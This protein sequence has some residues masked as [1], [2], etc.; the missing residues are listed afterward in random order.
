MGFS[1]RGYYRSE[2]SSFMAEWTAVLTIIVVNIAVWVANLLGA[3][4]FPVNSFLALEGDLP[5]HLLRAWELVTYGFVHDS[6]NPWHLVFNMLALWFFGREVEAVMGRGEFFRFYITAIVLAGIAWLVSVQIGAPLQAAR[7][8]LVGASGAVMAVFAVFIWYYPNQTVLLWGVLP[9]PAWALGILYFVSD[10]QGAAAGGGQVANVAHLAGAIFGLVYAW[11]G[12][13]LGGLA[14]LTARF[15]RQRMRVVRP[16]DDFGGR[17]SRPA[18]PGRP[19]SKLD[20][21]LQ[22]AVDKI[23]EKISRSGESSLTPEERDTLTR[24]SRR[25]K[26]KESV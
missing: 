1:D 13:N 20:A 19:Q 18:T 14:D 5:Q 16:E 17:P 25:L 26:E 2:S 11:R 8:F 9:V 6:Q 7:M 12:W 22:E 3:N 21:E 24:A 4:E 10:V 23:L 15:R